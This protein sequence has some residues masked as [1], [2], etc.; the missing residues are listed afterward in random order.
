MTP[1][2]APSAARQFDQ[3]LSIAAA[4]DA[5]WSALTT[6][7]GIARWFALDARVDPR[8]GGEL[9]WMWPGVHEWALRIEHWEPGERL[10]LVYD[11][12][13]LDGG[14]PAPLLVDFRIEAEGDGTRLRLVHAGFGPEAAFDQEF[15]GVSRGWPVELLGLRHALERHAG[16]RRHVAWCRRRIDLAHDE[17]WRRLTSADGLGCGPDV[18]ALPEGSPFAM[19]TGAGDRFEGRV[20]RA[21]RHELSGV[22]S[23][24][25]DA[26]L[27]VAV[28]SCG[29][30]E[31][32][33]LWLATWDGDED[34]V[35][36]LEARWEEQLDRLFARE[37][38]A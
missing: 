31:Q 13:A 7:E 16:R 1:T 6:P 12:P 28:E 17:T 8:A 4:P 36:A 10:A 20:L 18:D 22:V 30:E 9:T 14:D 24:L 19:T 26:F 27:R 32:V 33:W 21:Q 5:V 25:D 2:P 37:G 15:E 3:T 38:A 29:G 35:R 23:N 11:G 34:A